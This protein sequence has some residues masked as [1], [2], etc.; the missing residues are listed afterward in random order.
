VDVLLA[1]AALV[2]EAVQLEWSKPHEERRQMEAIEA[3]A[4]AAV[5]PRV[6]DA[7][8]LAS[9]TGAAFDSV[10]SEAY[11]RVLRILAGAPSEPKAVQEFRRLAE[12]FVDWWHADENREERRQRN[13]Q[14]EGSLAD[15]L[16]AYLLR[17]P[18]IWQPAS[19]SLS[20][21]PSMITPARSPS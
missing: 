5:R 6:L 17:A 8:A 13:Y 4:A 21:A 14:A 11:A 12:T 7:N 16:V 2:E 9:A 3:E 10:A 18:P 20:C 1:E 19:C 15:L